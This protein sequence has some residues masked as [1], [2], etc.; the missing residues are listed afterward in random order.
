MAAPDHTQDL[1]ITQMVYN[2]LPFLAQTAGNASLIS[3]FILEVMYELEICFKVDL[4]DPIP[5]PPATNIGVEE[6]YT[7]PQR[8]I[9]ADVVAVQILIMKLALNMGGAA[10]GTDD[11]INTGKF[12]KKTKAGSVEVEW[13]QTDTKK[14]GGLFTSAES[15]LKLYQQSASRKSHALGCGIC[16]GD[17]GMEI[18]CGCNKELHPFMVVADSV[19]V[20]SNYIERG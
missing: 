12:L 16:W 5:V 14:G 18:S 1:Q 2:R 8:V 17:N 19:C 6:I 3:M 20:S 13:E 11:G 10:S 7:I 4:L 15:L 9:I